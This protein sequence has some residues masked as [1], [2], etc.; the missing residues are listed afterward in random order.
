MAFHIN[1]CNAIRKI[2]IF[3]NAYNTCT[4][5]VLPAVVNFTNLV[6]TTLDSSIS[7]KT[8]D[9]GDSTTISAD[10]S[11]ISTVRD[12]DYAHRRS[13]CT[14]TTDDTTGTVCIVGCGPRLIIVVQIYNFTFVMT[15]DNRRVAFYNTT[16]DTTQVDIIVL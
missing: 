2:R 16:Y 6:L 13:L 11:S 10:I 14:E 7:H 15:V 12:C 3:G 8:G 4:D 9:T 1:S 5:I